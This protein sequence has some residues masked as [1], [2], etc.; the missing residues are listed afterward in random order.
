MEERSG[1]M[2]NV[3]AHDGED[4]GSMTVCEDIYQMKMPQVCLGN[5][6]KFPC[7]TLIDAY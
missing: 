7:V 1:T 4:V 5:C 6:Q 2:W 3:S